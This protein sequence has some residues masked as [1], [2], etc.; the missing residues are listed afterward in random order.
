[1]SKR[2]NLG[3]KYV[4]NF[5]QFARPCNFVGCEE[6]RDEY[7]KELRE[8]NPGGCAACKRTSLVRKYVTILKARMTAGKNT[9]D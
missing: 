9:L 6:L 3:A 1:M 2:Y 4:D 7:L 5:F 8:P